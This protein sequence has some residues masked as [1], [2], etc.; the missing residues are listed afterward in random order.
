MI[1]A[2]KITKGHREWQTKFYQTK[3]KKRKKLR[4]WSKLKFSNGMQANKVGKFGKFSIHNR[5]ARSWKCLFER[6][7]FN[8]KCE[9]YFWFWKLPYPPSLS[10]LIPELGTRWCKQ[11]GDWEGGWKGEES[12][13]SL[14]AAHED[15][16]GVL[17]YRLS[18]FIAT[19]SARLTYI[20]DIIADRTNDDVQFSL[21]PPLSLSLFPSHHYVAISITWS[22]GIRRDT[23]G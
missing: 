20:F 21:A 18:I 5:S 22:E 4:K 3:K 10:L 17:E 11:E 12:F 16:W 8:T 19:Q 9:N 13:P 6:K 23:Q 2:M 15:Q 1:F 7:L 14:P